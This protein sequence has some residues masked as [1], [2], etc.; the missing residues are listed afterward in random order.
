MVIGELKIECIRKVKNNPF[1]GNYEVRSTTTQTIINERYTGLV[2]PKHGIVI[3]FESIDGD[4]LTITIDR[5]CYTGE[6]EGECSKDAISSPA[7]IF[8]SNFSTSFTHHGHVYEVSVDLDGNLVS[9]DEWYNTGDFED[10]T[11]PD[12]HYT[13]KSRGIK[14]ELLDR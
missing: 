6:P 12:N 2:C 5:H 7:I 4:R 14:W 8:S 3:K 10:G 13:A 11:E 1:Y 9:L